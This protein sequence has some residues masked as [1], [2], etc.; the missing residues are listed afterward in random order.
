[1]AAIVLEKPLNF[2]NGV[3]LHLFPL[4]IAVYVEKP[5]IHLMTQYSLAS[6]VFVL[7]MNQRVSMVK[8]T[9]DIF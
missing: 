2:S 5:I 6:T 8:T 7:A 3:V 4:A 9:E 1:M